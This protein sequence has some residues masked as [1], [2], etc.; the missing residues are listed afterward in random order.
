MN[1]ISG[2]L[3]LEKIAIIDIGSNSINMVFAYVLPSEHFVV[4]DQIKESV[5]LGAEMSKDGFLKPSKVSEA[6]KVLKMF[7]KLC[8]N[9][10]IDKIY[11]VATSAVRRAKNQKSLLEEINATCGLKVKVVSE[12][13][14]AEFIFQAVVNNF[15]MQKG[16][17]L[18]I[19]GSSIQ[20]IHYSRKGIA[21]SQA[22]RFGTNSLLEKFEEYKHDHNLLA[23]KVEEFVAEELNDIE[24]LK[25]LEHG[26][27]LIGV[28]GIFRSLAK[29]TMNLMR[30][31]LEIAH[32]YHI[33]ADNFNNVY[34][35]LKS[36]DVD[37][38]TKIKGLT[39]RA[40]L[41][42]VG[43]YIT[44]AI[45]DA[46]GKDSIAISE[47][48]LREGILFNHTVPNTREKAIVDVYGHSIYAKL[49]FLNEDIAHLDHV[50]NLS[51]QLYK[52]LKVLHKLPRFYNKVLRMAVLLHDTG[53]NIRFNDFVRHSMYLVM[54]SGISGVS[55]REIV[56][57]GFAI[58]AYLHNDFNDNEWRKYKGIVHEEDKIAAIK[59][60]LVLRIADNLDRTKSKAI[61]DINCDILGDSIIVKTIQNKDASLEISEAIK[62]SE[63]SFAR[64][65]RKNIKII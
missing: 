23:Q 11:S 41:L 6:V 46:L 53:K 43:A 55:H 32:N 50:F 57:A 59:I 51:L 19:S 65:F 33:Q 29:I 20:L 31:P 14:E 35:M 39:G 37:S 21:D 62:L 27:Q 28:G 36:A 25:N 26:V 3:N 18:D 56:V 4:F 47:Y 16:L 44:K 58:M 7:K 8:D 9:Q 2:E 17:I 10:K 12:R 13:E 34:N 64:A 15:D 1:K 40:D 63:A 22:I 54:Y 30:Y 60:G 49:H 24:W 38:N 42:C 61:S 48:G 5:R 45:V 52:Q